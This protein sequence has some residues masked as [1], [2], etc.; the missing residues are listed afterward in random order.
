ML[1][2]IHWN[3]V[4]ILMRLRSIK[5]CCDAQTITCHQ[6]SLSSTESEQRITVIGWFKW[7]NQISA[8]SEA[9]S[10]ITS[11]QVWLDILVLVRKCRE[12]QCDSKQESTALRDDVWWVHE[13]SR[14]DQSGVMWIFV[15][16]VEIDETS[17]TYIDRIETYSVEWSC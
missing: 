7:V 17:Q 9:C 4:H 1:S 6:E 11:A 12:G 5:Q 13:P 14:R 3:E 2:K 10:A 16:I 8:Q 15:L